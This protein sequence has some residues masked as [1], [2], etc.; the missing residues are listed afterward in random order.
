MQ[1]LPIFNS[2]QINYKKVN[3]S[4]M[5]PSFRSAFDVFVRKSDVI[6]GREISKLINEAGVFNT[7]EDKELVKY[8]TNYKG[9]YDKYSK[10]MFDNIVK[11]ASKDLQIKDFVKSIEG[12]ATKERIKYIDGLTKRV[13]ELLDLGYPKKYLP[14]FIEYTR[15]SLEEAQTLLDIHEETVKRRDKLS[16]HDYK[17]EE[18][19]LEDLI[20]KEPDSTLN[21]YK[22]MGKSAF[23]NSFHDK[24]NNVRKYIKTIGAI[25]KDC[26]RYQDLL[27]LVNPEESDKYKDTQV[28]IKNLKTRWKETEN[29]SLRWALEC[30]INTL[31]KENRNMEAESIKDYQRKIDVLMMYRCFID[32]SNKMKH[33]FPLLNADTKKGQKCRNAMLSDAI[34]TA[35]NG[36]CSR[37]NF[38]NNK[39]LMSLCRMD[40]GFNKAH[41]SLIYY[42]NQYPEKDIANI[43]DDIVENVDTKK[44]F[45]K[46]GLNY[47]IWTRFN[48]KSYLEKTV[49]FNKEKQEKLFISRLESAFD[50]EA[51]SYIPEIELEKIEDLMSNNGMK[52]IRE[53]GR[54]KIYKDDKPIEFKDVEMVF[55]LM[56]KE[57]ATNDFWR[58]PNND[59]NIR[60]AK[61]T[62]EFLLMEDC[63]KEYRAVAMRNSDEP[64][65]LKVQ[66]VDMNNINHSYFLGNQAGNCCTAVGSGTNQ[67]AAPSYVLHKMFSAIEVLDNGESIGNTMCYVI[68]VDG[69]PAIMLDSIG[70]RG[71]YKY[72]D[73]IRDFIIE[74]AKKLG[75]EIGLDSVPV[76]ASANTHE[77]NMDKFPI[78]EVSFSILGKMHEDIPAYFDFDMDFHSVTPSDVFKEELYKIC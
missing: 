18:D 40:F 61:S 74:Y 23:F 33:F 46:N 21:F 39:Y 48:P 37:F 15:A 42:I 71:E 35:E 58:L 60:E 69:K 4:Q 64:R 77:V 6:S 52:F 63:F 5:M 50:S 62:I 34:M 8:V 13:L 73:E 12:R 76:Y 75:K 32:D 25:D 28:Q 17:I 57:F 72:V 31:T 26:P 78:K 30:E 24:Y 68:K 43:F 16:Y 11:L 65:K 9:T 27:E 2:D 66:K 22:L 47:E 14:D 19:G 51:F 45:Q 7:R 29:L 49:H 1:I 44:I 67:D 70:L 38:A 20:F 53:N 3:Y 41:N 55:K 56:N 10:N 36:K 59:E 54:V